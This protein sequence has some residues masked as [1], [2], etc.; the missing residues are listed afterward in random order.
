MNVYGS[1]GVQGSVGDGARHSMQ[2]ARR[3]IV[4]VV[5]LAIVN[6]LAR[7]FAWSYNM[8]LE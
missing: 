8:V 6:E 4:A 7:P 1:F 3:L 5:F 2:N